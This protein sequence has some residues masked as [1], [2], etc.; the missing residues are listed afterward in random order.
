M[1]RKSE[2]QRLILDCDSLFRDIIRKRDICCQKTGKII[3]LHVC[4]FFSRSIL[5]LRWN[6]MN[7]VLMN[8]GIHIFWC[9]KHPTEF[10]DWFINH[11]GE[12]NFVAL[13][14]KARY[15]STIYTS[16]LKVMK[17]ALKMRLEEM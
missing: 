2:R 7:A 10:Q 6:E 4:H 9:H 12:A 14:L 16:D 3:N 17:I 5:N 1:K 11:I 15:V 13:K 8:G